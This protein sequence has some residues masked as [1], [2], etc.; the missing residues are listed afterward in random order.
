LASAF[1]ATA[2]G[3][4]DHRQS[5]WDLLPRAAISQLPWRMLRW[6]VCILSIAATAWGEPLKEWEPYAKTGL[7]PKDSSLW[8][9]PNME[10]EPMAAYTARLLDAARGHDA[11]AMATLGRFFFVRSD[12]ERAAEW[13]GKAARAG[14]PGAQLDF[15]LMR[16]RGLGEKANV[17]EAYAW[18]WLA[19]WGG[20]PGAD[21]TL[22]QVSPQFSGG[23][24]L[25]GIQLA[26]DFQRRMR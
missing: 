6:F 23:E 4:L 11:K 17:V 7:F 16:L 10:K 18:L 8:L 13:L 2:G 20:A 21:E 25:A 24:V 1:C 14:H 22:R 19:S 3:T 26:A 9:A 15:G 12:P 5:R